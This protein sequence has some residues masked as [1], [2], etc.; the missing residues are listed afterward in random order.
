MI[1][2]VERRNIIMKKE[3]EENNE[4][5]ENNDENIMKKWKWK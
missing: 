1:V 2:I 3:N 4:N 5:D